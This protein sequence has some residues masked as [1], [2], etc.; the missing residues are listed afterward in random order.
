MRPRLTTSTDEPAPPSAAV[1]QQL[2]LDLPAYQGPMDLLVDLIRKHKI[3]IFDIPIALITRRYLEEVDRMKSLDL[4]VGG[5][6][7]EIAATLVHIKSKMLLP[8]DPDDDDDEG[9]DPREELVRQLIEYQLFKWAADQLDER[10]QLTRDFLLA[11]PKAKEERQQVG[12]PKIQQA[13][14][15]DLV[16]ALKRVIEDQEEADWAYEITRE[17]LTLR[18]VITQIARRLDASPRIEFRE[19]FDGVDFTRY[20]VATTFLALL[21]MTRLDMI[22]LFQPRLDSG[23]EGTLLIERAVIDIVEITQSFDFQEDL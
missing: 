1:P 4:Q 7:L 15:F 17:K 2:Q 20:R 9:P 18:S 8:D 6:W 22:R 5:E 21:E 12:P 23:R 3:D 14:L 11:A 13:S 19:L 16:D 10:P